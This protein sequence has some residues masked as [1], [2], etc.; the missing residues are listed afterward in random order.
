MT[1]QKK[2][3]S[4]NHAVII[5]STGGIGEAITKKISDLK[6]YKKIYTF[7]RSNIRAPIKNTENFFLD[8]KNEESISEASNLLSSRN[9]KIDLLII[10]TGILHDLDN[11]KPEKT[12]NEINYKSFNDVMLI[13]AI[14]P[15]LIAKYFIPHF[16]K[17]TKG[18]FSAI[19]AKIGS[20]E[21]NKLGGW[22]SYRA[23]KAALNMTIKNLSIEASYKR[24]NIIFSALH[25]GT[26]NT[27]LSKPFSNN[28]LPETIVSPEQA[29][30]N[31]LS[32]LNDFTVS[33]SGKIFAY[34]GSIIP[35]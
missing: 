2:N 1:T 26:V 25:P 35:Y 15:A 12:W 33:D 27:K 10:C 8:L 34:D 16:E 23:S 18:L 17:N 32:L 11:I 19:S 9:D 13:N 5:G 3:I 29:A 20:I 30:I 22:Y 28:V 14:G 4:G 21:D 31:L 7:N 6:S 24:P